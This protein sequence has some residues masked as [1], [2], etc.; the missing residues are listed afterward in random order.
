MFTHSSLTDLAGVH[1]ART[2]SHRA[3]QALHRS[4]SAGHASSR[5]HLAVLMFGPSPCLHRR[6]RA[7]ACPGHCPRRWATMAFSLRS[8][9]L[10]HDKLLTS[11]ASHSLKGDGCCP[12]TLTV[13]RQ[14]VAQA[15]FPQR[16]SCTALF[17][18]WRSNGRDA[19][20]LLPGLG[21]PVAPAGRFTG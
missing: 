16:S 19:F 3:A 8:V 13:S 21:K 5:M 17:V 6:S 11:L 9:E 15:A 1:L 14:G 20:P 7:K 2:G 10:R 4:V 12:I 18:S